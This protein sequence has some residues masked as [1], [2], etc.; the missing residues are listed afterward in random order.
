MTVCHTDSIDILT[1][2]LTDMGQKAADAGPE[3][4]QKLPIVFNEY[5][6]TWGC[7]SHT[8]ILSILDKVKDRGFEYFVIDCGWYKA[9]GIPWDISMGDYQ[10]S[11]ELFPDGLEKNVKAIKD[12]GLKPGIWFEIENVGKALAAY[13]L[14]EHLL[15]LDGKVLTTTRRRFWDMNDPRVEA[16][17]TERVIGLLKKYGFEYM[18]INYNDTIGIGCDGTESPGEGLRRNI[19]KTYEF[20][21]KYNGRFWGL[22][23]KTVRP[24]DT[25]WNRGLW[26]LRAW[27]LSPTLMNA[28]KSRSLPR[29]STEQFCRG[30]VRYGPCFEKRIHGRELRIRWLIHFWEG[31][32]FRET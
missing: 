22:Y 21:E 29:I 25:V 4:E 3:S 19:E 16:Y 27:L 30:R 26:L 12:A 1:K 2:R 14:E 10:V 11:A 17:L 24:G 15:R 20:L 6:T 28:R 31:C 32:A 13:Q 5:C 23:W 7:P 9:E 8:N 18:K